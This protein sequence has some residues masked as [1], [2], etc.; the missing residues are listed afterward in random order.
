MNPVFTFKNGN[1]TTSWSAEVVESKLQ[2]IGNLNVKKVAWIRSDLSVKKSNWFT[3][4]IWTVV[5]KHFSWMRKFFFGVNLKRSRSLLLQIGKQ[6]PDNPNIKEI[7]QQVIGK[8]IQIAPRHMYFVDP[9]MHYSY[10][11]TDFVN[12]QPVPLVFKTPRF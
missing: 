8:F 11:S 2:A 4:L 1:K 7:Y 9:R 12:C 6:I 5:A 3:R 10:A